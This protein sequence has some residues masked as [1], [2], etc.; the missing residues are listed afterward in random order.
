MPLA[1]A[2]AK[3][4]S[5]V[6]DDPARACLAA[7]VLADVILVWTLPVLVG[8]DLPQH[9]SYARILADYFDPRLAFQEYFV[10]PSRPQPYFTAYL[11]LAPLTRMTS[12]LTACRLLYSAYVVATAAAFLSLVRAVHAPASTD[13]PAPATPAPW[14]CVLGALLPWNPV[15]CVGFLP[16]MLSL[17]A[18]LAGAAAIVR[19]SGERGRRRLAPIVV[20]AAV[21]TSLHLVAGVSLVGFAALHALFRRSRAGFVACV[22][23]AASTLGT[24]ALWHTLGERGLAEVPTSMIAGEIARDGL[25]AGLVQGFGVQWTAL[26]VKGSFVVATV[27][28][29]FVRGAKLAVAVGIA[30]LVLV[31][32]AT[33][34]GRPEA[35]LVRP[36]FRPFGLTALAFALLVVVTP[37]AIRVPDDI[38]LL[39]FRLYVLAFMLGLACLDPRWFE[40]RAARLALSV[41]GA[42]VLAVW[43]RQL[44]G[45]AL[46]ATEVLHLVAQLDP[47]S[48][49]LS[50]PFHDRS[51]YLDEDNSVTHYFPVY[52]TAVD[53]GVTSSF[54]GKFSHHLPVGFRA[55]R[56]PHKPPDWDTAQFTREEL[57]AASHVLVEWPD[58][59]DGD[60]RVA[61]A[62]RLRQELAAGFAPMGCAGRW[63]LFAGPGPDVGE[64]SETRT[65][66]RTEWPSEDETPTEEALR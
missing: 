30:A 36:A 64:V 61:A 51:E 6:R 25:Y 18:V 13:E 20:A 56:E 35:V 54:W 32:L 58:D 10:L 50:L 27:L 2:R 28:G 45:A 37:A 24:L 29:P 5:W 14:T 31:V 23:T 4:R 22:V 41:F 47:K 53:G 63:C 46:E 60:W 9:L 52:Y 66:R 1:Q 11:V 7:L 43:G 65:R 44:R 34:R 12:V 3:L 42:F 38:C 21:T 15:Q 19:A 26:A 57:L 59:D 33:R 40:P 62:I 39:D 17:P 48:T 55:G 49:L 16:F 8:Q